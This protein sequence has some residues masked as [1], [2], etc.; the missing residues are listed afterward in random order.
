MHRKQHFLQPSFDTVSVQRGHQAFFQHLFGLIALC[1]LCAFPA[2]KGDKNTKNQTLAP[3]AETN[4][5]PDNRPV[6]YLDGV[7]ATSTAAD[8]P[9]RALFDNDPATIWQTQ[10]GAGPD[11]GV[12]LYFD[13]P[14]SLRSVQVDAPD[15]SFAS[16]APK[17]ALRIYVNGKESNTG[18]PGSAIDISA[19]PVRSLYVRVLATGKEATTKRDYTEIVQYPAMAS[20][21]FHSLTLTNAQGQAVRLAPPAQVKGSATPSS[22]LKP[23]SAYSIANLFDA[24][25]EFVWCE[26]NAATDGTDETLIFT[27][28]KPVRITAL[29]CWNGY[30]RSPKHFSAN[31][32]IRD[33]AFGTQG[34]TGNTYTLRDD[35][36]AQTIQLSAPIEGN[37]FELRIKS[38]YP[39]KNYKD[40]ALSELIFYDG[41]QP[42]VL[43]VSQNTTAKYK[44]SLRSS[45]QT[46][47]LQAIL[48]R[49]IQNE[50][51]EADIF[52]S[53][54]SL[55]LRDDGT[56]VYYGNDENT[57]ANALAK[58]LAD[59]NWE[60]VRAD[61]NTAEVRV[62]GKWYDMSN[63]QDYYKGATKTEITKIFNDVLKINATSV[64]GSK[65]LG[66][67]EF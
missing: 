46:T 47:P 50:I 63:A 53:T 55:V 40:L 2:C 19:E 12:M 22:T 33:F 31:T 64:Q 26:G 43:D 52:R 45:T 18:Q 8:R 56:F 27:F 38:T 58:T 9:V 16:P 1:L 62:F 37:A 23:E 61:A 51:N 15:G 41:N 25:K 28:E 20:V 34:T 11:E 24:R 66:N 30:Q 65:L 39:G 60:L 32:R 59:G 14:V 13:S 21:A 36:A 7:Y 5:A 17:D 54:R 44:T 6:L 35:A 3:T 42:F 67:F 48:N 4:T 10:N 29:K 49:R 57:E